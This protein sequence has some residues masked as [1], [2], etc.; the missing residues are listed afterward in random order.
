MEE[1]IIKNI[2][3]EIIEYFVMK[4]EKNDI[5]VKNKI[6]SIIISYEK[7]EEVMKCEF[8]MLCFGR[9]DLILSNYGYNFS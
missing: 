1:F 7:F 8:D 9:R 4:K 6:L 2:I 5:V 3:V